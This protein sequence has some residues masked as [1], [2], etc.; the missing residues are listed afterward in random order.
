MISAP[1]PNR[2]P[3]A[4]LPGR[5]TVLVEAFAASAAVTATIGVGAR[6][7]PRAHVAT[8]VGLVFLG[9][10][11]WL[12]WRGSDERVRRS[13][14]GLGGLLLGDVGW[15]AV[16]RAAAIAAA[17]AALLA[18]ISFGPYTALW[19]WWWHPGKWALAFD[20]RAAASEAMGQLLLISLPEEA[21][22]R[23][24]LQTRLD[25]AWTPRWRILGASLGPGLVASCAIFAVGHVVTVPNAARL[26]VFFPA[27]AFGWLRARTGGIGAALAFHALCNLYSELLG[28]GFGAY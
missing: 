25:E 5:R 7:V 28:R 21:F 13:G 4:P 3:P 19:W 20:A 15:A 16:A 18:A 10:T 12:V 23:G 27:L 2:P 22:Y 24:Y 6:L 1:R 8:F 14:L 11:W 17:W 9:A 26:G